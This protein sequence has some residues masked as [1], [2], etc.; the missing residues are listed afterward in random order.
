MSGPTIWEILDII[1]GIFPFEEAE[2]WDNC[3]L[4]IGSLDSRVNKIGIALDP[5]PETVDFC[6]KNSCNLLITHHPLFLE[7]VRHITPDNLAGATCL[8]AA[9]N[10]LN[11]ISLHTNVDACEGGLNDYLCSMLGLNEVRV[12]GPARCARSGLLEKSISLEELS[13]F[14]SS[15]LNIDGIKIVGNEGREVYRIFLASG[16]GISYLEDA[17]FESAQVIITGDVKYH[18]AREALHKGIAVLDA[19]HFGLEKHFVDL[20]AQRLGSSLEKMGIGNVCIKCDCETDP[21]RAAI[22]K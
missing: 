12:P 3:G 15:A 2:K 19:G 13:C 17:A 14:V 18:S 21:F 22:A 8:Y 7:G 11:I 1:N 6:I 16:S 5:V 10:N 4:Q 20:V 9:K